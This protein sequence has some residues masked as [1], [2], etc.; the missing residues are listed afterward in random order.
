LRVTN[1][2]TLHGHYLQENCRLVASRDEYFQVVGR[3][4]SISE[5]YMVSIKV[6]EGLKIAEDGTI[7][8][9]LINGDEVSY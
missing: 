9:A 3:T 2:I 6:G 8:L 7:S 4:I 1:D 5:D